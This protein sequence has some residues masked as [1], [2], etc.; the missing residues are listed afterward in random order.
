MISITITITSNVLCKHSNGDRTSPAN[1][2]MIL[3]LF[4]DRLLVNSFHVI[5]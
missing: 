2:K 1:L 3:K 5:D 4:I